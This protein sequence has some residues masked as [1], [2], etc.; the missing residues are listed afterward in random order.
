MKGKTINGNGIIRHFVNM[1]IVRHFWLNVLYNMEHITNQHWSRIYSLGLFACAELHKCQSCWIVCLVP[2]HIYTHTPLHT[3][4]PCHE[5]LIDIIGDKYDMC[6][7]HALS[8]CISFL[9]AFKFSLV[10]TVV[11]D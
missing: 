5:Q 1:F 3:H 11:I 7:S 8:T 10:I 9:E 2:E 6:T 4:P